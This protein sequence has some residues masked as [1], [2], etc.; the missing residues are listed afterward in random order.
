MKIKLQ[1]NN[2]GDFMIKVMTFGLLAIAFFWGLI[3]FVI[4][5]NASDIIKEKKKFDNETKY[6]KGKVVK[7]G[8]IMGVNLNAILVKTR[9]GKMWVVSPKDYPKVGSGI[10]CE[11]TVYSSGETFW[12]RFQSSLKKSNPSVWKQKFARRKFLKCKLGDYEYTEAQKKT[13]VI[14]LKFPVLYEM[15]RLAMPF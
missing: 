8:S 9:V 2:K 13:K 15:T 12:S 11:G 4:T 10:L 14:K 6:I 3:N 1:N 5:T 7:L